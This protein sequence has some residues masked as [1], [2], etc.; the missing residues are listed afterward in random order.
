LREERGVPGKHERER[1]LVGL[2]LSMKK[3]DLGVNKSYLMRGI[4]LICSVAFILLEKV[5]IS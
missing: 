5:D 2:I 4:P 1:V 3:I